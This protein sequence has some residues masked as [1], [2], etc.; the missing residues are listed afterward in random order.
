MNT[1]PLERTGIAHR[2]HNFSAGPS[3]LPLSVL[4]RAQ[5]EFV[6]FDHQG[7]SLMEMSHRSHT[8]EAMQERTEEKLRQLLKIPEAYDILFLQGGASL[9]FAMLPMNFLHAGASASYLLTGAW[10]EKAWEE[11]RLVGHAKIAGSTK[12]EKYRRVLRPDE[13]TVLAEDAYVHFTTNNTIYGTQWD[14]FPVVSAPLVADMSSDILSRPV[15]VS[16]F[17]MIYA[18]AQKNLGPS[19]VTLVVVKK[20]WLH[21]VPHTLPMML[22]YDILAK[23]KSRYNTPPT[24]GI[25]M[26]GLVLDWIE[27][28]GGAGQLEQRNRAKAALIYDV[29]DEMSDFYEGHAEHSSRSLMNITFRLPDEATEIRFLKQA[30]DAGFSG[31]PGHRSVGGCR[32]S[33]YNASPMESCEEFAAFMRKF[34]YA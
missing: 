33:T 6:D 32:V 22:R 3:A 20:D 16:K 8:F 19:G 25:Y 21:Q 14:E 31:L 10:A 29:I 27:E 26:F 4:Q 28:Q 7:M 13:H 12:A 24:F 17:Y 5:S 2:V 15:D 23:N 34:R 1:F 11:G 30:Q 9:Q 18:G